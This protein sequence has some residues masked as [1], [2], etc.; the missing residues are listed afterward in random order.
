MTKCNDRNK[1]LKF[2]Y[3]VCILIVKFKLVYRKLKKVVV[4]YERTKEINTGTKFSPIITHS[5]KKVIA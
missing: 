2:I 1:K 3:Q 5:I 4:M